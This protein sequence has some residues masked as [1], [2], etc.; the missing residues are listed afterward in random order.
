MLHDE[1]IKAI[2]KGDAVEAHRGAQPEQLAHL[3]LTVLAR[4]DEKER[5]VL[6]ARGV[7]TLRDLV[8]LRDPAVIIDP[9][10]VT[11]LY[12]LFIYPKAFDPGPNCAWA[13]LFSQAPLASYQA[14]PT[15]FRLD[16][17]PVYY[18]GRLA[19]NAAR[20]LVVGQDPS[21]DEL[22]AQRILVGKAGQRTQRLL[23]KLGVTRSYVMLNTF[24]Y[25]IFNQYN[26]AKAE[27]NGNAAAAAAVRDYRNKL[28]DRVKATNSLQAILAFGVAGREAIDQWP[29]ATGLARFNLTHPTASDGQVLASWNGQLSAIAAAISPDAGATV[30]LSDCLPY[31][32]PGA[33]ADIPRGDLPFGIPAFHGTGGGTHSQR[34]GNTEIVWSSVPV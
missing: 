28:F 27:L 15:A 4:L 11:H 23:A 29:G 5:R 32:D 18:R 3:P 2:F 12:C 21:T 13:Q 9:N 6:E 20:V 33:Y 16:F 26:D 8:A 17:G 34:N 31:T 1:H 7:T 24:L 14:V 10:I 19:D 30:D 25:G 22:L